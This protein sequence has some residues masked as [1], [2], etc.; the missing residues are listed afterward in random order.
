MWLGPSLSAV[1]F[2]VFWPFLSVLDSCVRVCYNLLYCVTWFFHLIRY[3][4]SEWP[5]T[6]VC[7]SISPPLSA[8]CD[9]R[10]ELLTSFR[11]LLNKKPQKT[12]PQ[13]FISKTP[14]TI[15]LYAN[16]WV[17]PVCWTMPL[18]TPKALS[19]PDLIVQWPMLGFCLCCLCLVFGFHLSWYHLSAEW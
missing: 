14:K 6:K 10:N 15:L 7:V 17:C 3:R 4:L 19:L 11:R 9:K 16:Q 18:V 2:F 13:R 5:T 12:T 1:L 8:K